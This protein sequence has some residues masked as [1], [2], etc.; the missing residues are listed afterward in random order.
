[1]FSVDIKKKKKEKKRKGLY[2][3]YRHDR[4]IPVIFCQKEGKEGKSG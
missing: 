2:V 1:M 3:C 4:G